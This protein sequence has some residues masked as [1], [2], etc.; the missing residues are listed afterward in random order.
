MTI[1]PRIHRVHRW[2][3]VHVDPVS[4][5]DILDVHVTNSYFPPPPPLYPLPFF[6][7]TCPSSFFPTPYPSLTNHASYP[8]CC[9]CC[10][11]CFPY[12][13]SRESP[14][15]W[16]AFK[17]HTETVQA[18]LQAP[19]INVNQADVSIY[20]L[21]LSPVVVGGHLPPLFSH[22]SLCYDVLVP[23]KPRYYTIS[24]GKILSPSIFC[25]YWLDIFHP[26]ML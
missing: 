16:A 7:L 10:C 14:L 5:L 3:S 24:L 13:L 1:S 25:Y 4:V 17:G 21:I 9:C 12:R 22:L 11:C 8:T 20:L 6:S 26:S 15:Y 23:Q 18:L 19:G 2:N